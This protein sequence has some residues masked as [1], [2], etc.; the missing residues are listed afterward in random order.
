MEVA[1]HNGL[2]LRSYQE[3]SRIGIPKGRGC[4]G[5]RIMNSAIG[6]STNTP[7]TRTG[8]DIIIGSDSSSSSS[9]KRNS[10]KNSF[11]NHDINNNNNKN[12]DNNDGKHKY[13]S[14][15][16]LSL[17]SNKIKIRQNHYPILLF[18]C[19]TKSKSTKTSTKN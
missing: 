5:G 16:L 7:S 2:S 13:S 12:N 9:S 17:S 10:F 14:M 8:T 4:P 1:I 18:S 19:Q 15:R 11:H 6:S 3:E